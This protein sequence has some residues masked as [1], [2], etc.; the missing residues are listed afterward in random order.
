M[1][2]EVWAQFSIKI[3]R[4]CKVFAKSYTCLVYSVNA[5][6]EWMYSALPYCRSPTL[7]YFDLKF[8]ALFSYWKHYARV[9]SKLHQILRQKMMQNTSLFQIMTSFTIAICLLHVWRVLIFS[10]L[11]CIT[12]IT[13]IT[14]IRVRRVLCINMYANYQ[15]VLKRWELTVSAHTVYVRRPL[16][17]Q[18]LIVFSKIE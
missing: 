3:L 15:W 7:I 5:I 16:A 18:A 10:V 8:L 12:L 11:T 6:I 4:L 17:C 2:R 9:A 13:G 1:W 14:A